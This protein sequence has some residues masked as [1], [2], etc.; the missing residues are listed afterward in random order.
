MI[1]LKNK[2]IETDEHYLT[3]ATLMLLKMNQ[4]THTKEQLYFILSR[5]EELSFF[6]QFIE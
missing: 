1:N 3:E 6:N 2:K 4:D 5:L